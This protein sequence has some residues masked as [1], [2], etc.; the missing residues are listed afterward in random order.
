MGLPERKAI[1]NY[2]QN[3]FPVWQKKLDDL[4]GYHLEIEVEWDTLGEEGMAHAFEEGFNLIYFQPVEL[5]IK[6]IAVDDFSKQALKDGFKKYFVSGIEPADRVFYRFEDKTLSYR[7]NFS[8]GENDLPDRRDRIV[9]L[10]EKN[11]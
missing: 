9:G 5:G 7:H 3:V 8:G 4:L 11:L 2:K 6:A 10:F 1:A